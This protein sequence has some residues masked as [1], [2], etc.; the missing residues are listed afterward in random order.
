V[1]RERELAQLDSLLELTLS[2]QG[3]VVFV[4]GETGS[5]KTTLVQEFARRAQ[6]D[7]T[8]LVIASGNC[9][10]YTGIG[11][12]YLPFREILE[13]LTGDVEARWAAGAISG[14]HARRL[15]RTLPLAAQTLEKAGP[16]LI[17]TFIP[18]AAW[19]ERTMT[20]LPDR[21]HWQTRQEKLAARRPIGPGMPGPRQSVL[22]EQYTRVLIA[23]AHRVPLVLVV[24]DLQWADLG[25]I[26][27]LFHLC[28]RLAGSRILLVGAYRPEELTIGRDGGRHPLDP[29]VNEL[30]RD[31]GNI[32]LN[33]GRAENKGFVDALLD[34][35]PNRLGL[36]FRKMLFRQTQGHPLFTG[37]L[38]RGL[39]ERG[40][41]VRDKDGHWIEG[42][43]LDWETLPAR[44]EAVIAE[45][46]G[47]LSEPLRAA[48]RVASVEGVRFTAEVIAQVQATDER[49]ML[50]R[51]SGELDRRH[52]LIRAQSIQRVD[53]QLLSSYRFR[54]ILFQRYL[55]GSL[56]EVERVHMHDQVGTAL[57]GLYGAS[58]EGAAAAATVSIA[59]QLA[60]HFQEARRTRKA[61]RY[62]HQAG[63]RAA[64]LSAYQEAIAHYTRGLDLLSSLPDSPNRA[65]Q[66]LALLLSLGIAWKGSMPDPKGEIALTRA[67]EL[68]KRTGKTTELAR[69]LGELAIFPYVRAEHRKARKL[70]EQALRMAQQ[71]E[72]PLLGV[73]CHWHLGYVS[74]ALGEFAAARDHLQRVISFY[75]PSVH[76]L[77]FVHLRG[78][79]AGV[80]ALAYDACCLWCLGYPDQALKR[81]H[82]SVALARELDHTFSLVDVL[83]FAGCLFYALLRDA[84]G[85]KEYAEEL[86]SL[87]EGLGST[88]F[89]GTGTC[90]WGQAL[91]MLGQVQ[92]GIAQ[93]RNGI[94]DRRSIGARCYSSGMLGAL[95]EAQGMDGRPDAG[96]ITVREALALVEET[97]ERFCEA[98]LHRLKGVQWLDLGNEKDAE[99]SFRTAIEVARAQQAKSWELRATTNLSR[100]WLAQSRTSEAREALTEVYDWFSEGFDTPDLRAARELLGELE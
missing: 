50:E 32:T 47:R 6:E 27:L 44:V 55:Y 35:E 76:H 72:D 15:W 24:D 16:D 73:V 4:T 31:L 61:I 95:A 41:L 20:S 85:L 18:R 57:E 37:E 86:M 78:S 40:D 42:Q 89:W 88:S 82:K 36:P 25:S 23:L 67:R 65:D 8:D 33:L 1:A 49:R 43:T 34:S 26:S 62:L 46:V 80:G 58:E 98:E 5:G 79:D 93:M 69:V 10:A 12:P 39:Q 38:L 96:L 94:A 13:L 28:R 30:Q 17:D 19:L 11:D 22:F 90:Y 2:G 83:C 60:L 14:E 84:Q 81:G 66:E 59:P 75:Q 51:L 9:N 54:H 48:L 100:L 92:V 21:A 87:S 63:K 91:S 56:D 53:E 29:V 99:A 7:H 74:F 68:C 64:R 97:G 45:R 52:H 3:R 71:V 77:P 70:G